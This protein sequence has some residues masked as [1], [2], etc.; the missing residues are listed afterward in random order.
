VKMPVFEAYS[1]TLEVPE[2]DTGI[3]FYSAAGLEPVAGAGFVG[4]RCVGQQHSSILIIG[5]MR[6][7]RLHYVTLRATGLAYRGFRQRAVESPRPRW[8]LKIREESGS[9]IRRAC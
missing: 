5:G 9:A 6:S 4:M 7:K 2:R 8:G 3:A 1:L